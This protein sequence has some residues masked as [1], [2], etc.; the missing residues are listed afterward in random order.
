[1]LNHNQIIYVP[2][3]QYVLVIRPGMPSSFVPMIRWIQMQN[4]SFTPSLPILSSPSNE[5]IIKDRLNGEQLIQDQVRPRNWKGI[6]SEDH[7]DGPI[8]KHQQFPRPPCLVQSGNLLLQEQQQQ[9]D[10]TQHIHDLSPQTSQQIRPLHRDQYHSFD[11]ASTDFHRGIPYNNP[12]S[13][14]NKK[15]C[16]T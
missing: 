16:Q 4:P 14:S 1:M 3:I 12:N 13:E 7:N 9:Q 8:P 2:H 6:E 10:E 15:K 11:T 5:N